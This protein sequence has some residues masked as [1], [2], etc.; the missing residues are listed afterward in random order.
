MP[1]EV[2]TQRAELRGAA[3][4]HP[5]LVVVPRS[6]GLPCPSSTA[7][8]LPS[9]G[10]ELELRGWTRP[11][12][13]S[14]QTMRKPSPTPQ[15]VFLQGAHL[16]ALGPPWHLQSAGEGP[17]SLHLLAELPRVAQTGSTQSGEPWLWSCCPGG[18]CCKGNRCS[19][20]ILR[21]CN[22]S[23]RSEG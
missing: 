5:A 14:L 16:H 10:A 20:V 18:S 3:P 22:S 9:A 2:S 13:L 7:L 11:S 19:M 12:P 8:L 15:H 1:W 23:V 4:C 17:V 21:S 6:P